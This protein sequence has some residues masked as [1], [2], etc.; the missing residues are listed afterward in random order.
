VRTQTSKGGLNEGVYSPLSTLAQAGVVAFGGHLNKQGIDPFSQTGAYAN[1]PNLY[2]VKVKPSQPTNENRLVD[3]FENKQN[4]QNNDINVRTYPG[5]PGSILGV[6]NTNIRFASQ[7]TGINNK[8]FIDG[9]KTWTPK[10]QNLDSRKYLST[11]INPKLN[12]GVSGKY[13][14]LTN[15]ELI[16]PYNELGQL[17]QG[18]NWFNVYEP[19][20]EGNTWPENSPLI[21]KNNTFTY[22]QNDIINTSINI[23]GGIG[24]PKIQDFRA[25]LRQ[26]LGENNDRTKR[27]KELGQLTEAPSYIGSKNYESRVNIGGKDGKGPGHFGSKN[28]SSYTSGSGIGPIDKINA[29][30]NLEQ[31]PLNDLV[32]FRITF[33]NNTIPSNLKYLH[34]RAFLDSMSDSYSATWNSFNYLGRNESFYTYGGYTR[35]FSLSWTVAAQ[36]KQELIPMYKKLNFLAS[37]LTGDYSGDGYM[38]GNLVKLTVGGYLYE[39]PG[40]IT[41]LTYDVPEESPWEIG[42]NTSGGN[43]STVKELPHIIRVTGFNFIPIQTFIPQMQDNINGSRKYISLSNGLDN[44]NNKSD[45]NGKD[46]NTTNE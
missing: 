34:F 37:S 16:N 13:F 41:S 8:L 23:N 9:P 14:R 15:N 5:G 17:G 32:K 7:R 28:L 3:I 31:K 35:Q 26:S 42:I 19:A 4:K 36:S 39:Q 22:T 33:I 46:L 38:R 11:I 40:I 10:Q 6:G 43:D 18:Y 27:G 29:L 44:Y 24:S 30:T 25:V 2:S 45:Y 21:Y 20:V 1:N 12:K